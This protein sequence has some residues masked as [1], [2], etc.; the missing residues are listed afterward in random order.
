MNG[1][2]CLTS[3][4]LGIGKESNVSEIYHIIYNVYS[5]RQ[6]K[7]Q[8]MC[9][10]ISIKH[11]T[12]LTELRLLLSRLLLSRLLLSRLLLLLLEAFSLRLAL[13]ALR[14]DLSLD[15]SPL[16]FIAFTLMPFTAEV[17]NLSSSSLHG[18]GIKPTSLQ[19]SF[20]SCEISEPKRHV[21]D[22]KSE[23]KDLFLRLL[24]VS[25]SS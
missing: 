18:L 10:P 19:N 20:S 7:S 25:H 15:L 24:Q 4:S 13:S 1:L 8:S 11:N 6:S 21:F 2:N 16:P 9:T 17:E 5:I 12:E 23:Q 14:V 22:H 3:E